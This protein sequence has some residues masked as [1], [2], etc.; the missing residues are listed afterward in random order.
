MLRVWKAVLKNGAI[1]IVRVAG[2]NISFKEC[3]EILD[4]R[5]Y[6]ANDIL[7][8]DEEWERAYE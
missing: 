5:G 1:T 6:T 4:Y 3:L 2:K 8:L 7:S